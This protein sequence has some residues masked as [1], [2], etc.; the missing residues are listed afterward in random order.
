ER[1]ALLDGALPRTRVALDRAVVARVDDRRA[2]VERR[3]V[4]R[5]LVHR[6]ARDREEEKRALHGG[7]S[8]RTH[9]S[10]VSKSVSLPASTSDCFGIT[11]SSGTTPFPQCVP[12]CGSNVSPTAIT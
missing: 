1:I 10:A 2:A 6:A 7:A 3:R 12:P 4:R 11:I 5:R 9:A 8:C